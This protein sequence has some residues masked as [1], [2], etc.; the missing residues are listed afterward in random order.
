MK[1]H[2]KKYGQDGRPQ[3]DQDKEQ[4]Q[5]EGKEQ[6]ALQP[7]LGQRF[8]QEKVEQFIHGS[9]PRLKGCSGR[10]R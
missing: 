6:Q 4:M 1:I 10:E 7:G 9:P 5:G 3:G 2:E 8:G